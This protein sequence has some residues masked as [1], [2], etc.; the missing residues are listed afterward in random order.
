MEQTKVGQMVNVRLESEK[1]RLTYKL[2]NL[3]RD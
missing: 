1:G 3:M 2:Y